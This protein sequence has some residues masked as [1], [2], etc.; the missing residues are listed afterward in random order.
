MD[1]A[2]VTSKGFRLHSLSPEGTTGMAP[3]NVRGKD[4]VPSPSPEGTTSPSASWID[5]ER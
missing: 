3:D 1:D 5:R 4:A 2:N